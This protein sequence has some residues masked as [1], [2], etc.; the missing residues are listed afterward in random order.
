[1]HPVQQRFGVACAAAVT[2]VMSATA[3]IPAAAASGDT[4]FRVERLN[5][6]LDAVISA[7]ATLETLGDRFALTEGPVWVRE[8]GA[9]ATCCS[10][11]T[12]RTSSTSGNAAGR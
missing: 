3:A 8:P 5:P 1:M 11:T 6:A 4:P 12:R 9:T 7:D 2:F 10:A